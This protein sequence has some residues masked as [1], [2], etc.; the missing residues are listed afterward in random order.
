MT[1]ADHNNDEESGREFRHEVKANQQRKLRAQRQGDQGVWFGLGMFGL[2]GWSVAIPALLATALGVWI[3][4]RIESRY[5]W[6]LMLMIIGVCI[7]CLN[8]WFWVSRERRDIE[9]EF[10]RSR[11]DKTEQEERHEH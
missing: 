7:G 3:D 4:A 5:S 9:A 1:A 6:T 8:A 2:V 10:H 11:E